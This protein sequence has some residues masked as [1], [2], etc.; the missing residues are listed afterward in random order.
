MTNLFDNINEKDIEKLKRFLW[1]STL[2][3]PKN[4]NILSNYHKAEFI[5]IIEEGSI[6][7]EFC[8]YEGN[9]TIMET[10]NQGSIFGSLT[11]SLNSDE[12]SC[13]T[14]EKTIITYIEYDQITNK[15]MIK[16]D[17]YITFIKNLIK[18]LSEQVSLKNTRINLLTKKT[19]REKLLKYFKMQIKEKGN[20]TFTIPMSFTELAEYLSVDR[21]A[22]TREITYLKEDGLIK[23]NGK[24]ITIYY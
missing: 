1:A 2:T 13:I 14:K 6:D 16:N 23:T 5:A 7:I 24:R 20:N 8:D 17:F 15:E 19:T 18:L 10:L 3:Y 9:R 12:I 21:S 22:M 11:F 4:V